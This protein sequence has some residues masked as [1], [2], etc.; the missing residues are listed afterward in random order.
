MPD[1]S[2]LLDAHLKGPIQ[3]LTLAMV[4]H[5]VPYPYA[6]KKTGVKEVWQ[7]ATFRAVQANLVTKFGL[8]K[9]DV[10]EQIQQ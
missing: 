4:A 8:G 3:A 9:P 5:S 7:D 10:L 2:E 1:I 6:F